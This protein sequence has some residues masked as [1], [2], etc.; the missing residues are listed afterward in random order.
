MADDA[1]WR[2]DSAQRAAFVRALSRVLPADALLHRAE[3][4]KPYECDGLF[5]Y[6]QL[7]LAVALPRAASEVAAVLAICHERKVPVVARGAGTGLSG[8]AL[9][10]A[11]G[12]VLGLARLDRVLE[13]DAANR[14]ARVEPGVTN[15]AI[16]RAA[17]P[18]G[19]FYAPDPSSQI[20]CTIG[21][22]VAE[23]A[24][25]LHCIKYGLTTHNLLKLEVLTIDGERLTLGAD[26]LDA[27]GYDLL[28]LMTGSEGLLGVVV[29]AT[30]KLVPKPER[31]RVLLAAFADVDSAAAAV[32]A[33]IAAGIVP[34]G[35]EMM[36]NPSIRAVEAYVQ[37]GYPVEAEAVLLCELDGTDEE[38]ADD[39]ARVEAILADG[40]ASAIRIA[41]GAAERSALWSGR[42]AAF[43]ALG[44]MAPDY[45]CIDGSI[46]RGRLPDVLRGIAALSREFGLPVANVFHAGD[47]NLHPIILYDSGTP[48]EQERTERLGTAI[49]ALCVEAGGSV[50]GEHGVGIEKLD[51]MCVQFAA[52]E[53]GAFHAIKRAFDPECLLNPGK[54]V[55]TLRRCAEF[56][57]MHV[58]RGRLPFAHLERF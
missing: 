32:G 4:L 42:K 22:N 44:R 12:L 53:I 49:L 8:G 57:R 29:E 39:S 50:T 28:A 33:I 23:N 2:P 27:A 13:V 19:L 41:D 11:G 20:A 43:P 15:L 35:L 38:V 56:G 24:G 16:S 46:P 7:P 3:D 21:G 48:G 40:G 45:Y 51:A 47:G 31:V 34:A 17:A 55:P 6:R 58:H 26:A 25:G 10:I 54:A 30:V 5:C 36:D 18:H 9:P 52:A 37:C 14:S 1:T